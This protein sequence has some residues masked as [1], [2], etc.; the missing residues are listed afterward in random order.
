VVHLH[1]H[2]WW[3]VRMR[4]DRVP[5]VS[6]RQCC[7]R[8]EHPIAAVVSRSWRKIRPQPCRWW[9]LLC[10]WRTERPRQ[11]QR[12]WALRRV[13]PVLRV[14]CGWMDPRSRWVPRFPPCWPR[15]RRQAYRS[16]TGPCQW[17]HRPA[18]P[19]R[20]GRTSARRPHVGACAGPRRSRPIRSAAVSPRRW[21]APCGT[22]RQWGVFPAWTGV[23]MSFSRCC[24]MRRALASWLR[25]VLSPKPSISAISAW[26]YP[27]IA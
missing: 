26:S 14:G 11:H 21:P 4:M 23:G 13:A 24:N 17:P 19:Y 2:S 15:G 7:C 22:V 12:W 20:P 1:A 27:S 5:F 18:R 16:G 3:M 10:S 8:T 25:E 6:D 9:S